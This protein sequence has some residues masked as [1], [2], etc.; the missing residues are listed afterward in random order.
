MS[1]L[2]NGNNSTDNR[3]SH[4]EKSKATQGCSLFV[5]H[6]LQYKRTMI[7]FENRYGFV[8]IRNAIKLPDIKIQIIV[9]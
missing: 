7:N 2:Y 6:I 5:N 3:K 4:A 8:A 9:I 1:I